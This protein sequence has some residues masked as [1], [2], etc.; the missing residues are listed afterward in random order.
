MLPTSDAVA[1]VSEEALTPELVLV[2]QHLDRSVRP[3]LTDPPDTLARIERDIRLR[4]IA[5]LATSEELEVP[6]RDRTKGSRHVASRSLEILRHGPRTKLLVG[7][8]TSAALVAGLLLGVNVDFRG[9]PAGA[10]DTEPAPTGDSVSVGPTRD[11]AREVPA[12]GRR[13]DVKPTVRPSARE[14]GARQFAWAP[15]PGASG[16]H[17]EFFRGSVQVYSGETRRPE[18]ALTSSWRFAGRS[19]R[20]T[21]G[22]YRWYAWPVVSGV[23][24]SQATVQANLVIR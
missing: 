13:P 18:L 10:S 1:R 12:S 16:Y 2:D 15:V 11:S 17:V 4:R 6:K 8:L 5:A 21:Q 20:F 19:F 9:N 3:L 7:A 23:R 14:S 22:T 24:Q